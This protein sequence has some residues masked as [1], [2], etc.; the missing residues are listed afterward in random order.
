M[1]KTNENFLNKLLKDSKFL[2][3]LCNYSNND[4]TTVTKNLAR[5][6]EYYVSNPDSEYPN[7]LDK[8][9]QAIANSPHQDNYH[10]IPY[11]A[12]YSK[13]LK[14]IGI[15]PDL[16][17]RDASLFWLNSLLS[18]Q[19]IPERMVIYDNIEEALTSGFTSPQMLYKQILKQPG[20]H[21][22]DFNVGDSEMDYYS[23]VMDTRL[24]NT[25]YNNSKK[26]QK[27]SKKVLKKYMDRG[28]I[29]C[30][31]KESEIKNTIQPSN[32][33]MINLPTK[34]QLENICAFNQNYRIGS[35]ISKNKPEEQQEQRKLSAL[36]YSRV[37]LIPI[38]DTF[39][40]NNPELSGDASYDIDIVY[41]RLDYKCTKN[42]V[43]NNPN[44]NIS[45]IKDLN[46]IHVTRFQGEY[47]INNGRHRLVYLKNYYEKNKK[48]Y[49]SIGKLNELKKY[50][51]IPVSVEL[52][53][54][55]KK[56]N[57]LLTSLERT[58]PKIKFLK[59]DVTNDDLKLV[60][61]D[62]GHA[63]YVESERD[64]LELSKYL[65]SDKPL[66]KFYIGGLTRVKKDYHEL[67]YHLTAILK[68]K[69]FNM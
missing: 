39:I 62:Q 12:C 16:Y 67:F 40:Y 18:Y 19:P 55:D 47:F 35:K 68:E 26:I 32:F 29:L 60:I 6:I 28:V 25:K 49:E 11:N 23:G 69:L 22:Q 24:G 41:G 15:N 50:L 4:I 53:I 21:Q 13:A 65:L 31:I 59:A 5:I 63:Y 17:Y 3:A 36:R 43:S 44:E 64:I 51:T 66:N 38:D 48:Y 46:D 2:V 30:F 7:N 61:I 42:T 8:L 57:D 34:H 27:L 14:T 54:E 10:I 9:F 1:K 52:T 45:R 58:R 56:V 37:E 33:L 20:N